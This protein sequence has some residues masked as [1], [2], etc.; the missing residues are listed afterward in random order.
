ME[1]QEHRLLLRIA[2][3]R[4]GGQGLALADQADIRFR[5][6]ERRAFLRRHRAAS[7]CA[8]N[9]LYVGALE[10]GQRAAATE[11]G[12]VHVRNQNQRASLEKRRGH[13]WGYLHACILGEGGGA[14]KRS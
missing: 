11:Y 1:R 5:I 7:V 13:E 6:D 4:Q 2:Q 8:I 9:Q 14:V 3:C 12:V 10:R